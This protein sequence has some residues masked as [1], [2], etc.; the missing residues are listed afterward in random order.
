MLIMSQ[1]AQDVLPR[2]FVHIPF[3]PRP[4]LSPDSL[5]FLTSLPQE[6]L[7]QDDIYILCLQKNIPHELWQMVSQPSAGQMTNRMGPMFV[8]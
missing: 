5:A 8:V 3:F 7:T 6:F 4:K 1:C 2:I